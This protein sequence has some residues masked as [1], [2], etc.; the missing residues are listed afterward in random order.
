[1][2]LAQPIMDHTLPYLLKANKSFF[3][4][5]TKNR[6]PNLFRSQS[7]TVCLSTVILSPASLSCSV[8]PASLS[9]SALPH[10]PALLSPVYSSYYYSPA[11]SCLT[12]LPCS[13]LP[14]PFLL[15]LPRSST[16]LIPASF[17]SLAHPNLSPASLGLEQFINQQ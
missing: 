15:A 5:T 8:S 10:P 3:R 9:C 11:Q 2:C 4:V 1:M 7:R 6:P 16:L 12:I 14:H 13:D 17:L